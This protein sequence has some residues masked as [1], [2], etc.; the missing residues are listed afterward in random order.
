MRNLRHPKKTHLIKKAKEIANQVR[1]E[2]IVFI[3]LQPIDWLWNTSLSILE[4][5]TTWN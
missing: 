5:M 2:L 3:V 4:K 1:T